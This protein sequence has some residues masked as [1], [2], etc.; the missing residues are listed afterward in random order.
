MMNSQNEENAIYQMLERH[1][2]ALSRDEQGCHVIKKMLW[3]F[4]NEAFVIRFL[5]KISES[6][7]ELATNQNGIIVVTKPLTPG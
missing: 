1:F 6:L 2:V 3:K 5:E 4:S 7:H